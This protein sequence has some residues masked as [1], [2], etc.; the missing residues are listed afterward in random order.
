MTL[1]VTTL[2]HYVERN[3]L[4]IVMLNVIMLSVVEPHKGIHS[5]ENCWPQ[6]ENIRLS[7]KCMP[8]KQFRNT[9]T[10]TLGTRSFHVQTSYLFEKEASKQFRYF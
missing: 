7:W 2:S 4:F 8:K 3:I 1:S 6:I 10:Q 5:V 9:D